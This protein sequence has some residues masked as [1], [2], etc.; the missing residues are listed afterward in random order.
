MSSSFGYLIPEKSFEIGQ[1]KKLVTT[2]LE[3]EG[4]TNGFYDEANQWF[5]SGKN[6]HILFEDQNDG[7]NSA[8]EYV[9][10]HDT[11]N[12]RIIPDCTSDNYGAK[13]NNCNGSLDDN[14]SEVMME[15]ADLESKT[16]VETDMAQLVI[17]CQHCNHTNKINHIIFDPPVRLNNQFMCFV[18]IDSGFEEERINELATKLDCAIEV[19]YGQF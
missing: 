16:G 12:N 13:C 17:Q 5:A 7:T 4:I 11:L 15:M 18:E 19:L 2:V 14:L 10:I 1:F 3:K 8:F 6:A 9:E